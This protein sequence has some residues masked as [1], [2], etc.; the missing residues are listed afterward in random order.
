M[1]SFQSKIGN[2]SDLVMTTQLTMPVT[3]NLLQFSQD[4][5]IT[6]CKF[7]EDDFIPPTSGLDSS[8]FEE[9]HS[10]NQ[11]ANNG[12]SAHSSTHSL[13]IP[14]FQTMFDVIHGS[15]IGQL[16]YSYFVQ[17]IVSD[18]NVHDVTH[19]KLQNN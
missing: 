5:I 6:C 12:N 11:P 9:V 19:N 16:S 17:N 10:S 15:L 13:N 7:H 18:K 1:L 14:S 3:F 4:D 2:T 8:V